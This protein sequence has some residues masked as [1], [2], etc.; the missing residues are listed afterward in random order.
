MSIFS[1]KP[2]I[3]KAYKEPW[4]I[5]AFNF[6]TISN[7]KA[8]I[9]GA[10]ELNSPIILM[11]SGSAVKNLGLDMIVSSVN[12]LAQKVDIP[13]ILHLDH[14]TNMDL[15]YKAIAA[16]FTSVMYDGSQLPFE[17]NIAN[18]QKVIDFAHANGVSV[19]AELG[20]IG[21]G[22]EGEL[23]D[24]VLTDPD[25]TAEFFE[26]THVDALAVAVGTT[27]GMQKQEANIDHD[28]VAAIGDKVH[29]PLVL[30][31]SSGVA[32]DDLVRL[33]QTSIG[34]INFGT[35][36]KYVF[37]DGVK[38]FLEEHP[39]T[40]DHVGAIKLGSSYQSQVVKDKI[41]LINAKNKA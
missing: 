8:I 28:R 12:I 20:C 17:Q 32:D 16:G 35:R 9:Q 29:C 1:M 5:P 22:E 6:W 3:D 36:L 31:G 11:A 14:A 41:Q 2:F 19:E 40:S 21:R 24:E 15:I 18:T 30:H 33:C 25:Q 23:F 4:A 26:R 38:Q 39:N 34:K 27:H 13:V 7:A 10:S 37:I